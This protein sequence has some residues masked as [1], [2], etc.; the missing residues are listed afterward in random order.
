MNTLHTSTIYVNISIPDGFP[1]PVPSGNIRGFEVSH[2][3]YLIPTR[4]TEQLDI[5]C[6]NGS[7]FD[8]NAGQSDAGGVRLYGYATCSPEMQGEEIDMDAILG[9]HECIG[10]ICKTQDKQLS[11]SILSLFCVLHKN[12]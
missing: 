9:G 2:S 5:D 10:K 7:P 12:S 3:T 11:K 4:A 8:I 1:C 6:V